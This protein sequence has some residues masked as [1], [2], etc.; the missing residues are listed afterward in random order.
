MYCLKADGD[1]LAEGSSSDS[2]SDGY[3][4]NPAAEDVDVS[5]EYVSPCGIELI[6]LM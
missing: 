3:G 6:A 1:A 4:S 2:S 5:A